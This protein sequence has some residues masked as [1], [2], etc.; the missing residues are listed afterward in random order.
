MS[1][2]KRKADAFIKTRHTVR[3]RQ[4]ET[5]V[6]SIARI[7]ARS[8]STNDIKALKNLERDL[9]MVVFGQDQAIGRLV[10]AVKLSRSGLNDPERP[11]S[12]FLFSGPTGVGK[13]EVTRQLGLTLGI[14][15]IRFDMSEYMERHSVSRLIGSSSRLCGIQSRRA[16]DRSG[17]QD[18][19]RSFI[20]DEN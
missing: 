4:I 20:A 11:I 17:E 2:C 15:L 19:S 8:V 6:S 1:R 12:S 9:K 5:V 13:T 16:A 7:P 14:E 3:V 18:T 10:A